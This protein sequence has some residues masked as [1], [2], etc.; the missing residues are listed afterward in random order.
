MIEQ[1]L[2]PCLLLFT[3]SS[4]TSSLLCDIPF[5]LMQSKS[6]LFLSSLFPMV[7]L[8]IHLL[9]APL[10][11]L[12]NG[13]H[14]HNNQHHLSFFFTRKNQQTSHFNPL[15][16]AP[17]STPIYFTSFACSHAANYSYKTPSS[18]PLPI[19]HATTREGLLISFPSSI[20]PSA[21]MPPTLPPHLL[22]PTAAP[23]P[24]TSQDATTNRF[25]RSSLHL[26]GSESMDDILFHGKLCTRPY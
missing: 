8:F 19:P 12:F 20:S 9:A 21:R 13:M 10:L 7:I 26:G 23:P 11:Y 25:H 16:M 5:P 15:L 2:P 18:P 22:P 4:S 3:C 6:N 17:I 1:P 24:K 14:A